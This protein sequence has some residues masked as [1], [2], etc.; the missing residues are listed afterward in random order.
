MKFFVCQ[1]FIIFASSLQNIDVAIVRK[2]RNS[3][4][5]ILRWKGII[6]CFIAIQY[7]YFVCKVKPVCW[8]MNG[9]YIYFSNHSIRFLY[10]L[11]IPVFS[12]EKRKNLSF[13]ITKTRFQPMNSRF[14]TL[15]YAFIEQLK[16]EYPLATIHGHNEFANKACPCFDVKKEWG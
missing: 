9:I 4:I 2:A 10:I 6:Y 11:P 12:D 3:I 14:C 13:L 8:V 7:V 16:E 15:I 1:L 5:T